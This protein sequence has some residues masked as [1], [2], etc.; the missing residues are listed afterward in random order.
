MKNSDMHYRM[1]SKLVCV[2]R[3]IMILE[4]IKH[5]TLSMYHEQQK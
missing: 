3:C 5:I 1:Y 2:I 4:H